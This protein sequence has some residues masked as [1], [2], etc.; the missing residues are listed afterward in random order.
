MP[1]KKLN[2][3]SLGPPSFTSQTTQI[4]IVHANLTGR[5]LSFEYKSK[6]L[7]GDPD[8]V[9]PTQEDFVDPPITELLDIKIEQDCFVQMW[10]HTGNIGWY[11]R[12]ED[13]ITTV[14]PLQ[15]QYKRLE[16]MLNGSW[17]AN[18]GEDARCQ[19]IRFGA[20]HR[21]GGPR[22]DDPFNMNMI[23]E[24]GPNE[25]LPITIDPDIQNPKV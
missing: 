13:A 22:Q 15:S 4:I 25:V 10:L 6:I 7:T 3:V 21:G 19:G 17:T 14:E 23:L 5:K 20:V 1:N 24:W 9:L 12:S 11:W 8:T 18:P 2:H 16:Y